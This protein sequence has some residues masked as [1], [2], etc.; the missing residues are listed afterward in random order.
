MRFRS[1]L[2][3]S[4]GF[5]N[6]IKLSIDKRVPQSLPKLIPRRGYKES[7]RQRQQPQ[8]T[9]TNPFGWLAIIGVQRTN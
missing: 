4:L 5:L 9:N 7:S 8:F 6:P 1:P 2:D 3:R